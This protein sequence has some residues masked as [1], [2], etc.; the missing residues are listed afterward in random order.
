[1]CHV[2]R[3]REMCTGFRRGNMNRRMNLKEL[4]LGMMMKFK[5]FFGRKRRGGR[6]WLN[7][8]QDTSKWR[9]LPNTA[10]NLQVPQTA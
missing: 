4:G 7:L 6:H 9:A 8:H 2:W 5:W 10:I 1:M 3:I